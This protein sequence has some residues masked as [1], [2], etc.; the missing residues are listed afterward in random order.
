MTASPSSLSPEDRERI[1]T[2][3]SA[4]FR[5]P[6]GSNSSATHRSLPRLH[7]ASI[8]IRALALLARVADGDR[9]THDSFRHSRD[10]A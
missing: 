6:S 5:N 4:H 8:A 7:P 3:S 9:S 10:R 1:L 2:Q